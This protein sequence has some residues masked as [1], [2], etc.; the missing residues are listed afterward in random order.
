MLRAKW[1]YLESQRYVWMYSGT[2]NAAASWSVAEALYPWFRAVPCGLG[3][4]T[5]FHGLNRCWST[6]RSTRCLGD[7][8]PADR[9]ARSPEMAPLSVARRLLDA[10]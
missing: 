1:S 7:A 2:R 9:T 6:T 5:V 4:E 10:C 8:S 3:Q